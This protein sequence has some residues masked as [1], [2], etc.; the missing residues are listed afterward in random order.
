MIVDTPPVLWVGDALTLSSQADGLI[1]VARLKVLRQPML[2]ELR[3][4]LDVVPTRKLGYVITGPV[5]GEHG[6]YGEGTGTRTARATGTERRAQRRKTHLTTARS[7]E[8][9]MSRRPPPALRN[10]ES[11]CEAHGRPWTERHSA[12][13]HPTSPSDGPLEHRPSLVLDD[14][15]RDLIEGRRNGS[16]HRRGWI[17]RRAL[18]VA[19]TVGI[20][21]AFGVAEVIFH[22]NAVIGR[23]G[24]LAEIALFVAS[25]PAWLLLAKVYGLYD[26]DEERADHS[27]ADEVFSVFN[28]LTVGTF[29][30]FAFAYLSPG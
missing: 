30:F 2:R 16:T 17:V 18:I 1:V 7:S 11:G 5:S 21:A 28:M 13:Q 14:R 3:R 24:S 29:G 15:T 10:G 8:V 12:P 27:T 9:S 22:S 26:R 25:L 19:D 20:L 23:Y 4:I 6:V